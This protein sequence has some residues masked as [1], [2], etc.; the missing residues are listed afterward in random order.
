MSTTERIN[1]VHVD[2]GG[3]PIGSSRVATAGRRVQLSQRLPGPAST[4]NVCQTS[5][6][7]PA[8]NVKHVANSW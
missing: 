6:R 4:P 7:C 3:R 5:S 2:V 1:A 8:I